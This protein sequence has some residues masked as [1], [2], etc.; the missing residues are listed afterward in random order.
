MMTDYKEIFGVT[1]EEEE[2]ENEEDFSQNQNL[3][4]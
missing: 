4:M 1:V 3:I 2:E